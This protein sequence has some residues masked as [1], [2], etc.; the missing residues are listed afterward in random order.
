VIPTGGK[1]VIADAV[2]TDGPEFHPGK[3]LDIEMMVFVGGK[4]RTEVEFRELLIRSGFR[5]ERVIP[6][7]SPVTL[8]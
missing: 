3:L 8:L 1:L 5:L 4:E 7:K 6:T 2:L